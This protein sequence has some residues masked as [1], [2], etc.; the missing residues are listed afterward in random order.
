M[1]KISL[2]EK[3]SR[4]QYLL[5]AFLGIFL[6]IFLWAIV[7]FS[8][9]IKPLFLPT[10]KAVF[11]SVIKLFIDLHLLEDIGISIYRIFL[12]FI[13]SVAFSV[14]LGIYLGVNKKGQAFF[15]PIISFIRYI[16]PSAFVPLFILWFGIGELQKVILIFVG[17]AP[18]LT[19]L[20]FDVVANTK[21]EYIEAAYTLGAKQKNI[22]FRVVV[23]QSLPGIWDAMRLMMGAAWTLVVLAEII[24]ATSGLGYL[25]ITSQRFLQTSNVIAAIFIIG[26]LGLFTDLMFRFTY[27]KLFPWQEKL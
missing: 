26:L 5:L 27:K 16:P 23:P 19:L 20:I 14:P 10:P 12:G 7:S 4:G 2:N 13:F 1:K 8:G 15:E 17:V 25:I 22:I 18:Y 3:I 9:F 24:A 6:L 21:K 11:D